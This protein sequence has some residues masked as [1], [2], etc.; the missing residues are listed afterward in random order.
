VPKER[1]ISY[2]GASRGTDPSPIVAWAGWD[3]LQ[4]AQ[5]LSAYY[6]LVK[7]QD[8]WPADRLRALLAGLRELLPWLKQ[9]HSD[10]DPETEVRLGDHFADL[11]DEEERALDA[12]G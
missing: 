1:F 6:L 7:E 8:R 10:V 9:W 2:P 3:H 12:R 11:V 4:Q 5:A